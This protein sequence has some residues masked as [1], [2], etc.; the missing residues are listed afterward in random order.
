MSLTPETL[1]RCADDWV[2]TCRE[3]LGKEPWRAQ[4][5]VL[6]SVAKRTKG[7]RRV[8]VRSAN[9]TGK[10]YLAAMI[11]NCVTL[12]RGPIYCV[13]TSSSWANVEKTVWGAIRKM[14]RGARVPL[15]GKL[16]DTEWKLDDSW[17]CFAV[18]TNSPENISGFRSE[19][20]ACVIVDEASALEKDIMD[21]IDG[22]CSSSGS[23]VLLMGN[24][25]RPEGPFHEAFQDPDWT[26]HHI[27]SFM[28]PNVVEGREVI[29][30]LATREWVE[31]RRRSWGEGSP[32]WKIRVEGEFPEDLFHGL[33][34]LSWIKP[35]VTRS[36]SRQEAP[37]RLG[38]DVAR[39]GSDA[40]CIVARRGPEILSV[41]SAHGLSTTAVAGRVLE[42][43]GRFGVADEDVSI[44][45]TGVGGGV[46]DRLRE[47]GREPN[48]I[49]FGERAD[50]RD[51]FANARTEL[52]WRLREALRPD[53]RDEHL[54]LAGAPR[55]AV[56]AIK[57]A[58]KVRYKFTGD[59]R[60][61]LESK[62]EIRKRIGRSP[63]EAD[64]LVLTYAT[65]TSDFA[66]N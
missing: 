56:G 51:R 14:H 9:N 12:T 57:Q 54:A 8:A 55:E 26:C 61:Q 21:A 52:Y 28:T 2:F 3:V 63:D 20:G 60:I 38:V 46:T 1:Q 49:N 33:V 6:R 15:G 25:L 29:P 59:G 64:A 36:T 19:R 27:S 16:L 40:T 11:A 23:I 34:M 62:D 7:T 37:V 50:D 44:D 58:T 66:V 32:E 17:G 45:D 42:A 13:T 22:L 35:A 18:S 48:A 47:D 43:Q 53:S 39:Y 31:E 24:P 5:D 41:E 10:S 65:A 30:G 4:R